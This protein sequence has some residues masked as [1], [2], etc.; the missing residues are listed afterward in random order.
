MTD[1]ERLN[2]AALDVLATIVE[3]ADVAEMMAA[4]WASIA[5]RSAEW[6]P[7]RPFP[8]CLEVTMLLPSIDRATE[9][10]RHA[11]EVLEALLEALPSGDA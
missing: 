3:F 1:D 4:S 6:Y 9:R 10:G 5:R 7:P 8:S 11:A 2:M